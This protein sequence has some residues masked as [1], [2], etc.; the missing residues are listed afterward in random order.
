MDVR[1]DTAK[2]VSDGVMFWWQGAA[3]FVDVLEQPKMLVG[4]GT[5]VGT[6][7]VKSVRFGNVPC[8][9]FRFAPKGVVV[10]R[11]LWLKRD[12][13]VGVLMGR[14]WKTYVDGLVA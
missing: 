8:D 1:E 10:E 14:N 2:V 9:R 12:G 7:N 11:L 13:I 6:R 5:D 3:N 4:G